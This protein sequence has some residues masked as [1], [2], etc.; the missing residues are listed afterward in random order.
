MGGIKI[1][2][3]K[4]IKFG[5]SSHII[6]LPVEWLKKNKLNKGDTVFFKENGNGELLLSPIIKD[7]ENKPREIVINAENKDI[8]IMDREIRSAYIKSYNIIKIVDKN[9]NNKLKEIK[10]IIYNLAA[11]EIIE[12]TPTKIVLK[13]YLDFRNVS[14]ESMIRQM[15]ILTRSMIEDTKLCIKEKN[16]YETLYERDL[17]VNKTYFLLWKVIQRAF[18]DANF[19]RSIN[20]SY[21][22]MVSC[23]WFIINLEKLADE[24]KRIAKVLMNTNLT[25]KQ[26]E[27]LFSIFSDIEKDYFDVMKANYTSDSKLAYDLV[28]RKEINIKKCDEF[29]EKNRKEANI[30]KI[31]EKLKSVESYISHMIR[32]VTDLS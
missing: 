6:S 26:S 11:I 25:K 20:K 1:E 28:S 30:A 2:S 12:Q 5:N 24:T 17:D 18:S 3:R 32:G 22:Q 19:M 16:G 7:E 8:K 29:F 23:W 13:D 10:K 15:D 31:V 14:I 27:E 9:L 4:L 21:P